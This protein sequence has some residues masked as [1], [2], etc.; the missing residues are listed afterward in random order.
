MDAMD[1]CYGL[2]LCMAFCP[3]VVTSFTGA[4]CFRNRSIVIEVYLLDG[5]RSLRSHSNTAALLFPL[6][7]IYT[8]LDWHCRVGL[9]APSTQE[10]TVCGERKLCT[11]TAQ[12]LRFSFVCGRNFRGRA[13]SVLSN[14]TVLFR[15][16]DCSKCWTTSRDVNGYP[17]T[18]VP[19]N[20]LLQG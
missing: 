20:E 8:A 6:K 5:N 11:L 18:R 2:L 12:R 16:Y 13:K 15:R 10:V 3:D 7:M 17:G 9:W 19:V 1:S 4:C 14:R